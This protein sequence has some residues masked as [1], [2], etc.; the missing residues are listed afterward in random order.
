MAQAGQAT[1]GRGDPWQARRRRCGSV[2]RVPTLALWQAA[3]IPLL[4]PLF[5]WLFAH[6]IWIS[7]ANCAVAVPAVVLALLCLR[8]RG[9]PAKLVFGL[10]WLLLVP[11]AA[12]LFTDLGHIPY[13]WA[14]SVPVA[15]RPWF[16]GQ[17]LLLLVFAVAAFLLSF[18]PFERIARRLR[19]SGGPR[20]AL[21]AGCNFLVGYGVALGR[22]QHINS[23]I[24]LSNPPRVLRAALAIFTSARLLGL[25]LALG[26]R[27][28]AVYLL[29]RGQ[30]LRRVGIASGKSRAPDGEPA[31]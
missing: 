2:G 24:V 19:L 10:T 13:Q 20:L 16:L 7:L 8:A 21:L 11:N 23:W 9:R 12:Y 15:D 17:Y 4:A 6:H 5:R 30:L 14:H 26:A 18:L 25:T 29:A 3:L 22:F 27:C 1:H 31:A 28:A